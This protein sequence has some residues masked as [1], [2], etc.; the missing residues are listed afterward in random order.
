MYPGCMCMLPGREKYDERQLL[1]AIQDTVHT[2]M[3]QQ[4]QQ[5]EEQAAAAFPGLADFTVYED[6]E[7]ESCKHYAFF[8]ELAA[9]PSAPT[10]TLPA[11]PAAAEAADGFT[12]P[13]SAVDVAGWA[14]ELDV[15]LGKQNAVY[16][17]LLAARQVAPARVQLVAP[18]SFKA[19]QEVIVE[20]KGIS[21]SQYK[22][23]MVVA[24]DSQ[25]VKF[26][27]ERVFV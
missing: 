14:A 11:A 3:S 15:N 5:Q 17:G 22:L 8:W 10:Q 12:K 26:L 13:W 24:P 4:Q 21:P 9:P 20:A 27:R 19:L 18:G 7:D 2:L 1:Q 6:H 23:P 25:Y 16:A